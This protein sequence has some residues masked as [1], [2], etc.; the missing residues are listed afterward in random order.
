MWGAVEIPVELVSTAEGSVTHLTYPHS[1]RILASG[2]LEFPYSI[3]M[4]NLPGLHCVVVFSGL[5][6]GKNSE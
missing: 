2:M 3:L 1:E 4:H 5:V 6:E